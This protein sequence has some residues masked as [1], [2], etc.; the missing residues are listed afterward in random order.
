IVFMA[1][2]FDR[3]SLALGAANKG[4]YRGD[5]IEFRLFPQHWQYNRLALTIETLIDGLWRAVAYT[6]T[7]LVRRWASST[8]FVVAWVSQSYAR[9]WLEWHLRHVF[10]L[11]SVLILALLAGLDAAGFELVSY[12]RDWQLDFRQPVDNA[13]AWLTVNP[14]FIAFTKGLRAV[15]YLALLHPLDSYLTQ[16]PWYFVILVFAVV[17]W[18]S[19]GIRFALV[20]VALLFF[21]GACGLWKEAMLTLSSVLVSVFICFLIG[22]PIGIISARNPRV[23]M[24]LRPILDAMQTLPSFVYLIPVLMFFGGN[25]VSAVIATVVYA[26]PPVIRLTNLGISQIPA[27]YNEVST[28]FG[29]N[30]LQSL[31]KVQ[32]PMAL[33]SIM[34]GFNQA[35]MMALAMQVVTPLIGGGGLGREVFNALNMSNTGAGLEAGIGIVLLAIVL[36]RLSQAWS[37]KQQQALGL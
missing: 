20:C 19:A 5:R 14:T 35:V 32:L 27:T 10:L 22:M 2:M 37:A 28:A 1:I 25:I 16:L 15:V 7:M 31:S 26:L 21:I 4:V 29:S 17:G 8:A 33:P 12:P 30:V 9:L 34:L 13:V 3:F 36:D 24:L 6:F 11:S 18:R 23:Y